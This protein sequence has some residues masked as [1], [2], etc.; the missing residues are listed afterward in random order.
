M[1]EYI[2]CLSNAQLQSRSPPDQAPSNTK[3][4]NELAFLNV[5]MSTSISVDAWLSLRF[6]GTN[7]RLI[8]TAPHAGR[9]IYL[10]FSNIGC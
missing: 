3:A 9:W 1:E 10:D 5:D 6:L 8:D 2:S 7:H 4:L